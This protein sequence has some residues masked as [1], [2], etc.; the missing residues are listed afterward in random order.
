[1]IHEEL[2]DASSFAEVSDPIN[3]DSIESPTAKLCQTRRA[4]AHLSLDERDLLGNKNTNSSRGQGINSIYMPR[5]VQRVSIFLQQLDS[6]LE[7]FRTLDCESSGNEKKKSKERFVVIKLEVRAK[8]VALTGHSGIKYMIQALLIQMLGLLS[9]EVLEQFYFYKSGRLARL[10]TSLLDF[11]SSQNHLYSS[12]TPQYAF[13]DHRK[14][15][16]VDEIIHNLL[17]L[18]HKRSAE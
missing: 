11:S 2:A 4:N 7:A 14:S 18:L 10:L 3:D 8:I 17:Q 6:L 1:M 16:F 15:Q 9:I 13:F 12:N 5:K